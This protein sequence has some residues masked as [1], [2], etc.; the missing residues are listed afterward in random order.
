MNKTVEIIVT[1]TLESKIQ[2]IL[3]DK[4]LPSSLLQKYQ[5]TTTV[6]QKVV[7]GTPT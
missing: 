4:S 5:K 3:S 6:K 7:R 2:Y 1:K